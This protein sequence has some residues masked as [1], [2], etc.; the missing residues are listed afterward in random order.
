MDPFRI[1]IGPPTDNISNIATLAAVCRQGAHTSVSTNDSGASQCSSMGNRGSRSPQRNDGMLA[2]QK[3]LQE[4]L[5]SMR[6]GAVPSKLYGPKGRHRHVDTYHGTTTHGVCVGFMGR[7]AAISAYTTQCGIRVWCAPIYQPMC[8][9][10][11]NVFLQHVIPLCLRHHLA[12]CLVFGVCL[13]ILGIATQTHRDVVVIYNFK[14]GAAP[15][16]DHNANLLLVHAHLVLVKVFLATRTP[17][18]IPHP[19]KHM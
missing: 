7:G 3:F 9:P 11:L 5:P 15:V 6:A 17:T 16:F 4:C 18:Q 14:H 2:G 1:I 10:V 12:T 8:Y 13:Y 19:R